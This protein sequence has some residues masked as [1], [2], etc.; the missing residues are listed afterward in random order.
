MEEKSQPTQPSTA[1]EI[2]VKT[3]PTP[4]I[5]TSSPAPI[6]WIPQ[7]GEKK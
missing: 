6:V 1:V 3:N 5:V 7:P 4:V 2:F